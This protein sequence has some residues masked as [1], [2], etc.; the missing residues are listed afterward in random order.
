MTLTATSPRR[1][2]IQ[3]FSLNHRQSTQC[4]SSASVSSLPCHHDCHRLLHHPPLT[5]RPEVPLANIKQ[6]TIQ[7]AF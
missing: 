6:T 7:H 5:R 3:E 1:T 4:A 2:L